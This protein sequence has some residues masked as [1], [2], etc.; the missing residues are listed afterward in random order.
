MRTFCETTPVLH[1]FGRKF[2]LIKII[3]GSER[4][5]GGGGDCSAHDNSH[6]ELE[7]KKKNLQNKCKQ[8]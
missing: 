1:S 6:T 7:M 3:H 8:K 2:I 5:G 4:G